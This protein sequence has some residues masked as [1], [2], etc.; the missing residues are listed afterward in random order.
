MP[1]AIEASNEIN[2]VST[3]NLVGGGF[4]AKPP[5]MWHFVLCL[6]QIFGTKPQ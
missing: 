5:N 2:A 6:Q 3:N 4:G 1:F